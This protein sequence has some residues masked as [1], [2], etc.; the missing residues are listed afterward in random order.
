MNLSPGAMAL[1]AVVAG[2]GIPI[3]ATMNAGLGRALGHPA[4]AALV[5]FVVALAATLALVTVTGGWPSPVRVAAAPAPFLLGGLAFAFYVASVT[6]LV[7]RLGVGQTILFVLA[8]QVMATAAIDHFGLL[9]AV[10][11]PLG[12]RRLLG[13]GLFMVGLVIAQTSATRTPG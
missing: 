10:L 11:R 13:L 4:A 1:W 5:L 2:I 6:V 9:G 12:A 3:G 8:G 7:P